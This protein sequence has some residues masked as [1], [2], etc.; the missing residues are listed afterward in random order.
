MKHVDVPVDLIAGFS[1][2]IEKFLLSL[3]TIMET[4]RDDI[5]SIAKQIEDMAIGKKNGVMLLAMAIAMRGMM[6][7]VEGGA[8]AEAIALGAFARLVMGDVDDDDDAKDDDH[9]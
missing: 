4:E 8:P 6:M 5:T 7:E 1:G 2:K 3:G 9:G